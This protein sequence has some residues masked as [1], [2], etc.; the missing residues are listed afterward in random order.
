MEAARAAE[1]EEHIRRA[2]AGGLT[3]EQAEK[4]ARDDHEGET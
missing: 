1:R 3:R 2:M 4:H